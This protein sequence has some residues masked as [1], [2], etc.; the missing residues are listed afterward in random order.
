MTE[1]AY[2][3]VHALLSTDDSV[4]K[5]SFVEIVPEINKKL[6]IASLLSQLQGFSELFLALFVVFLSARNHTQLEESLH[7]TLVI[8]HLFR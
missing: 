6:L 4:A 5:L 2:E 7:F 8:L 3:V 1:I